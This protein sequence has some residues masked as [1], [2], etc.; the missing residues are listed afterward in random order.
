MHETVKHSAKEYVNGRA[1]TNGIES[2]WAL[3]KRGYSGTYHYFSHKHLH[4]YVNEFAFRSN[5]GNCKVDIKDRMSSLC[6]G[7]AGRRI[8]YLDLTR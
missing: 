6:K 4:R 1:H 2:I 3:L 5:E 8:S 7:I